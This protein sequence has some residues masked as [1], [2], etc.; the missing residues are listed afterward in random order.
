MISQKNNRNEEW[1]P[2]FQ[3]RS[4]IS[5]API[6]LKVTDGKANFRQMDIAGLKAIVKDITNQAG[7]PKHSGTPR[8]GDLFIFPT[9]H[10]QQNAFLQITR[11]ANRTL[12]ASLPKSSSE[13]KG[14]IYHV[15]LSETDVEMLDIL[16]P[17]GATKVERFHKII[18]GS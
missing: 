11:A 13:K 14:I 1:P 15:P 16:L 10:T 18:N 8:G 9:D 7:A 2:I 5:L 6:I 3:H 17:Q 12:S 4:Q